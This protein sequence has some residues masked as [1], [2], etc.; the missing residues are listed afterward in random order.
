MFLIYRIV[1]KYTQNRSLYIVRVTLW[2]FLI[3]KVEGDLVLQNLI[4]FSFLQNFRTIQKNH[5][6]QIE[7]NLQ[8]LVI[9]PIKSLAATAESGLTKGLTKKGN[10]TEEGFWS[11]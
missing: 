9:P 2:I 7:K 5:W 11:Q 8:L 1:V 3:K 10:E 6:Q 4:F